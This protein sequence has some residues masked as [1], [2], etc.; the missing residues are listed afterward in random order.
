M[1]GRAHTSTVVAPLQI[2]LAVVVAIAV[3]V[4]TALVG[5]HRG[6]SS[7]LSSASALDRRVETVISCPPSTWE[8]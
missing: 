8:G 6:S 3:V 1:T 5:A 4:P 7:S 2:A